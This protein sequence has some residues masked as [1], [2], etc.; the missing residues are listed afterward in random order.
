MGYW[1]LLKVEKLLKSVMSTSIRS[2][3]IIITVTWKQN[4][5]VIGDKWREETG[6]ERVWGGKF[7][8]G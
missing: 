3:E 8:G 2:Y 6:W 7:G 1:N 5:I 4:K